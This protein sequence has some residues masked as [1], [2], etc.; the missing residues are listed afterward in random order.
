MVVVNQDLDRVSWRRCWN[1]KA[2]KCCSQLVSG[3]NVMLSPDT[4][5]YPA[6]TNSLLPMYCTPHLETQA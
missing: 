3:S 2:R 1:V 5:W 4:S 6:H